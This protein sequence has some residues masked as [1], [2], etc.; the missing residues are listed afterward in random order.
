MKD[1]VR[2]SD[3]TTGRPSAPDNYPES[4]PESHKYLPEPAN[5]LTPAMSGQPSKRYRMPRN[6]RRAHARAYREEPVQYSIYNSKKFHDAVMYNESTG[7]MYFETVMRIAP[8]TDICIKLPQPV[9][10]KTGWNGNACTAR[11]RWCQQLNHVADN[12]FGIGVQYHKT[13]TQ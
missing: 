9:A 4:H 13:T 3:P 6:T 8:G 11:V 1:Q 12:R 5:D 2:H 10:E 7:G